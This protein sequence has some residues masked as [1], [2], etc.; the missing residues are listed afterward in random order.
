MTKVIVVV[1]GG[2]VTAAYS[3]SSKIDVEVLDMDTD[4]LPESEARERERRLKKI[5]ESK[6]FKDVLY[7]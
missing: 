4:V 6:S 5:E 3:R 2:L 7:L 1:E